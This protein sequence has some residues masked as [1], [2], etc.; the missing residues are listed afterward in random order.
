MW[1]LTPGDRRPIKGGLAM[2]RM[3]LALALIV[4][5]AVARADGEDPYVT[6]AR[7]TFLE[8]VELTRQSQWGEALAAFERSARMRPHAVT[9]FN[10]G[11]CERALGHYVRARQAFLLATDQHQK[12]GGHELS[13]A[14][15]REAKT[16]LDELE[17]IIARVDVSVSPPG[18]AAIA[19]DGRPLEAAGSSPE[20]PL[21]LA[22]TSPPGPGEPIAASTFRVAVDPGVHVVTFSRP[23]FADAV[24]N[25]TV[26][27]GAVVALRIE[28][29]RLPSTLRIESDRP[30]AIVTLNTVDVGPTPVEVQRPAGLYHVV[31]KSPGYSDYETEISTRPGERIDLLA[32]LPAERPSITS[33]WWFWAGTGAA[34]VAVGAGTY[35]LTRTSPEPQRP[36]VDGGGLGWVIKLQ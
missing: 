15:A 17:R 13:D 12:S 4:V 23:G 7:K 2:R 10:V 6:E 20:G 24:V 35:F 3:L 16:M 36:A 28:L 26:P 29:D 14:L 21:F 34:L 27:P 11:A 1:R 25:R 8:G 9:S 30:D 32:K 31:V 5:P 22:G 19:M 33:R 18:S